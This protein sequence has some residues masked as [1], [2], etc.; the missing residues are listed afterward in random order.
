MPNSNVEHRIQEIED[1]DL[2]EYIVYSLDQFQSNLNIT[3]VVTPLKIYIVGSV[4]TQSFT[5]GHSDID[6]VIG[7][8]KEPSEAVAKSFWREWEDTYSTDKK[9]QDQIEF[10]YSKIDVC[11]VFKDQTLRHPDV[12]DPELTDPFYEIVL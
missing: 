6:V 3:P 1:S 8:D 4:L 9:L 10:D 12:L 11:S 7:A 5:K 2:S